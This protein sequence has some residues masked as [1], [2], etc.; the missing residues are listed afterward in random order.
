MDFQV[1]E[2][3]SVRLGMI[4]EFMAREVIPLEGELLHGTPESLQAGVAAAQSK[5]KQMGLW[6][7]NHPVEFGGLGLS[8]VYGI[9][10]QS[11]GYTW[12]DSTPGAGTTSPATSRSSSCGCTAGD[13]CAGPPACASSP[14]LANV[15]SR[16][17]ASSGGF[18][19]RIWNGTEAPASIG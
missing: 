14:K 13:T 6:A 18:S 1:S 4:S 12:I 19:T 9:V 3:M 17:T 5:V 16:S 15:A 8:M 7:P 2:E 10:K 11:G